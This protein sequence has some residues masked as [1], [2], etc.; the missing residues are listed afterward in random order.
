MRIT[1]RLTRAHQVTIAP[2]ACIAV[3]AT[4]ACSS[5]DNNASSDDVSSADSPA[6]NSGQSDSE[7]TSAEPGE[8]I[9]LI[10][11][12]ST[13]DMCALVDEQSVAK[14]F[15]YAVAG[16]EGI[17]RGRV[18]PF[19]LLECKYDG[20]GLPTVATTL[21]SVDPDLSDKQAL[22]KAFTD[23]L[24]ENEKP[25]SYEQ[26]PGLGSRAGFGREATMA[27]GGINAWNLCIIEEVG[28]ERVL[29]TVSVN[30]GDATLAQ[31]RPLAKQ[32]LSNLAS[33]GG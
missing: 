13:D 19:L 32:M 26:V 30:G 8:Q 5:G 33:A 7:Q 31:V 6:S 24:E 4:G 10:E 28:N 22:D 3:L 18:P 1:S 9:S 12:L 2:L 27:G 11:G 17:S 25:G 20:D 14:A 21:E 23:L 29:L 15:D 16:S